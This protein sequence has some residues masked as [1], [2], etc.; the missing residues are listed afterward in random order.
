MAAFILYEKLSVSKIIFIALFKLRS[1]FKFVVRFLFLSTCLKLS[2]E[3][4]LILFFLRSFYFEYENETQLF[5]IDTYR[6]SMPSEELVNTSI[7]P[8]FFPNGPSGVFNLSA[9]EQFGE[10]PQA[11]L[12]IVLHFI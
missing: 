1:K 2:C 10:L 9:V 6:Y 12:V 7:D 11:W 8:G 3:I 4:F 5:G